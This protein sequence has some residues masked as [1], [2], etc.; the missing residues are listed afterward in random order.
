MTIPNAQSNLVQCFMDFMRLIRIES[1]EGCLAELKMNLSIFPS[2]LRL[3]C[4]IRKIYE[5]NCGSQ[6]GS[7]M[8]KLLCSSLFMVFMML[9]ICLLIEGLLSAIQ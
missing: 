4:G 5:T 6:A 3:C 8:T 7:G 9:A 2:F 1:M